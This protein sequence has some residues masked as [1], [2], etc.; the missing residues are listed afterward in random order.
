M[1]KNYDLKSAADARIPAPVFPY[2]PPSPQGPVPKIGLI[3]C[4]GITEHHLKAYRAA[5]WD[6]AAF[7]DANPDAAD[8]RRKE[9]YPQARTFS[10]VAEMLEDGDIKVVDIATHPKVRA[11]LIE[12]AIAAGKHILSQKPFAVDLATGERLV[13]L[14]RDAGVKMAVNQNGRWAPYFSYMRHTVRSGLIG[15]V[16]SVH[17]VLNWDHTWTAGTPFEDI[18]HLMLYDFGIHW[19]D[20]ARSFFP[21]VDAS[22]VSASLARFPDQPIKPPLL[23]NAVIS[24]PQ[25]MATLA[26]NG[27]SRFGARETCTIIGTKGTLHAV[28][29]I[30]GI[31]SVRIV[32]ADGSATAELEGSWFP[33]GFRGCMGELLC[34]IEDHREPDNSAAD[35]LK[36]LAL[37]FATM[38]SADEGRPVTLA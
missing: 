9:F 10:N 36:T 34:A 18:H 13:G 5:G 31:S 17:M 27:C 1:S 6:V 14:A 21:G 25:G 2:G 38:Q 8:N 28:G 24:F 3:G 19:L 11:A 35:N 7:Y 26:F 33:D 4:G 20:A 30:C 15:E 32:T 23:A 29:D 16:G 22:S 12:Q 37:V